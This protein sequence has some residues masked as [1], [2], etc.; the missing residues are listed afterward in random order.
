LTCQNGRLD[1]SERVA[2]RA[3]SLV[4]VATLLGR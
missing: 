2:D 1:G 3:V 4:R